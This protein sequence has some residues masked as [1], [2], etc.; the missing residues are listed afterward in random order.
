LLPQRI[1]LGV[2]AML[3]GCFIVAPIRHQPIAAGFLA[4][5]MARS[6]LVSLAWGI[7]TAILLPVLTP[8]PLRRRA[9]S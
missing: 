6:L 8:R 1:F 9:L 2:L 5:P 4:W 7:G 3:A